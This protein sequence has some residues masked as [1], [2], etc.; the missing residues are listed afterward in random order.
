MRR[1]RWRARIG[2]QLTSSRSICSCRWPVKG[3]GVGLWRKAGESP[4]QRLWYMRFMSVVVGGSRKDEGIHVRSVSSDS[5]GAVAHVSQS[6]HECRGHQRGVY[7][8]H[9]VEGIHVATSVEG[10]HAAASLRRDIPMHV[11]PN[12]HVGAVSFWVVRRRG[13]RRPMKLQAC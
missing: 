6:R 12:V 7:T 3:L 1:A 9:E 11:L 2:V 8:G 10:F 4:C 5:E 13:R